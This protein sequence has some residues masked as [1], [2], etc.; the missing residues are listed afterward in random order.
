M[1]HERNVRRNKYCP[2]NAH[3]DERPSCAINAHHERSGGPTQPQKHTYTHHTRKTS[4][5]S[6][7]YRTLRA[8]SSSIVPPLSC[9]NLK[10]TDHFSVLLGHVLWPT[11]SFKFPWVPCHRLVVLK[12]VHCG[13]FPAC[14]RGIGRP[15]ISQTLGATCWF[16]PDR[17]PDT[18]ESES[19]EMFMSS[20]FVQLSMARSNHRHQPILWPTNPSLLPSSPHTHTL[21]RLSPPT[22]TNSLTYASISCG[23]QDHPPRS[24]QECFSTTMC[25]STCLPPRSP[26]SMASLNLFHVPTLMISL[27]SSSSS[28]P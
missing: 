7:Y 3:H 15:S 2:I 19:D 8:V 4:S 13:S 16:V 22:P 24:A 9:C 5:V 27:S 11:K 18:L 1:P 26:P 21:S 20:V 25:F 10:P 17:I 14:G 23:C 28:Q 12:H 6:S